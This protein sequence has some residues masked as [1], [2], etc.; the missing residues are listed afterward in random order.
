MVRSIYGGVKKGVNGKKQRYVL[1]VSSVE[2]GGWPIRLTFVIFFLI[3]CTTCL[4]HSISHEFTWN[5][6]TLMLAYDY[7]NKKLDFLMS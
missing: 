3:N 1:L 6:I 5:L 7:E 4:G 2:C